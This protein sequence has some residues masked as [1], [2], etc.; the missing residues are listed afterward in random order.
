MLI[1]Q[2]GIITCGHYWLLS[3]GFVLNPPIIP[4]LSHTVLSHEYH[5]RRLYPSV[6]DWIDPVTLTLYQYGAIMVYYESSPNC[7]NQISE[8]L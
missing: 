5:A 3:P 7:R 2:Q 4:L 6:F 1:L 8:M